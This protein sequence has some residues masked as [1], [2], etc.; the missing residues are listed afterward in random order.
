MKKLVLSIVLVLCAL[1]SL[2][3]VAGMSPQLLQL[4]EAWAQIK[5]RMPEAKRVNA[6]E[7]LSGEA[8][9]LVEANPGSAEP[10]VW[11]A[12]IL[13]TLAG[14]KGGL[15]AL[16]LVKQAKK[17]LERAEAFDPEV[18][19][20]SVYTSL[21]S[22]YYQVPGWPIGFGDDDKAKQYL[23]KALAVNP[24]GMDPNYFYGDFMLQEGEYGEA[25]SA[26]ERALAAPPRENR[27]IA[28]AGRRAEIEAALAEAKIAMH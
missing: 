12:I 28:D 8:Q 15:G 19:A 5:Y 24:D 1:N 18:L 13:S 17:L 10:M 14:E 4:S 26:F 27:P 20:G 9:A 3:S 7:M 21:G 6:L 22:L 16:S 23:K 25:A 11:Q 2:A